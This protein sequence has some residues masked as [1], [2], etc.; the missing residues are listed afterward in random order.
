[1]SAEAAPTPVL[2][3]PGRMCDARLWLSQMAALGSERPAMVAPL[4]AVDTVRGMAEAL[5]PAL[6]ERVILVGHGLGGAVAMEVLRLVPVRIA[7]L[8]LVDADALAETPQTVTQRETRLVRVAGGRFAEVL[9]EET[10]PELFPQSEIRRDIVALARAMGKR[11]GPDIW[12]RQ[13]KAEQRRPD[14]QALLRKTSCPLLILAGQENRLTPLRRAEVMAG[15]ARQ[16]RLVGIEGAAHLSPLEA[17]DA[18]TDALR[19]WLAQTGL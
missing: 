7:G 8:V 14:Q 6:P 3:L 10:A 17:S 11:L 2:F 1:V 16:A 19:A 13:A 5:L 15:L 12:R 4:A 9:E 18:V